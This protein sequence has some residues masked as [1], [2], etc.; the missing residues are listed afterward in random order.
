[1]GV[2]TVPTENGKKVLTMVEYIEREAISEG[3][4]KY[5][6]KNPPNF[7]YGEGFDHGLDRAQRAI[8]DA[9]AAA[10]RR[11]G[12]GGGSKRKNTLLALCTI[13]LCAKTAFLTTGIHGTTV[14]T[15]VLRW[16][17]RNSGG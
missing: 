13:V 16:I 5:Y 6:Y 9:P 12:M 8:L 3:I 11:S 15:A 1:M 4:R 10:L 7:S 17:W 14:P 2:F